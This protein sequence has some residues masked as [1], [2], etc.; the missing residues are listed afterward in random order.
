MNKLRFDDPLLIDAAKQLKGRIR[1]GGTL[2]RI[3]KLF[4]AIAQGRHLGRNLR[5][6][7]SDQVIYKMDTEGKNCLPEFKPIPTEDKHHSWTNGCVS[8]QTIDELIQFAEKSNIQGRFQ[9]VHARFRGS[10][11]EIRAKT[12]KFETKKAYF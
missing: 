10:K 12:V 4:S 8:R 6:H 3:L 1:V 2:R 11:L 5:I 9:L 7:W